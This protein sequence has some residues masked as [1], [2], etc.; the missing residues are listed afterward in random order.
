LLAGKTRRTLD[1]KIVRFGGARREY[2]ARIGTDSAATAAR[3]P[4]ASAAIR[5]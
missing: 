2:L 5:Q 4:I 3:L 1:R